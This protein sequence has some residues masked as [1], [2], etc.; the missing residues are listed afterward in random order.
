MHVDDGG[1]A[2]DAGVTTVAKNGE[3]APHIRIGCLV[4]EFV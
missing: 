1:A 2:I 4:T 3:E